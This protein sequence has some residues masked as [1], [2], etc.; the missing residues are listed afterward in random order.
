[1]PQTG[2]SRPAP[3]SDLVFSLAEAGVRMNATERQVRRWT[4]KGDR[5]AEGP[6]GPRQDHGP[7]APAGHAEEQERDY[8]EWPEAE[9]LAECHERGISKA[10]LACGS[11]RS[12][13]GWG[14]GGEAAPA[15]THGGSAELLG[16]SDDDAL[17]A[18]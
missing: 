1:M 3:T 17:R 6:G 7:A 13:S 18:T 14:G 8:D 15:G 12:M 4:D 11:G 10:A 9:V 16:Q 2:R 5:R